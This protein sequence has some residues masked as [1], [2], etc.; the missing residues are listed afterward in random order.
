M[1]YFKKANGTIIKVTPNH[2]INSLKERFT[3]CDAKGNE[4]KAEKP[5][6]EAKKASKKDKKEDK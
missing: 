1:E 4:I 3:E 5:K 6:K 2:D